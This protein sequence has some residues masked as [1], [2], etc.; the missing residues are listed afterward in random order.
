M[1]TSR[2]NLL[3]P[4]LICLVIVVTTSA[5]VLWVGFSDDTTRYM[6]LTGGAGWPPVH[7]AFPLGEYEQ[8]N[9]TQEDIR[10]YP[11][12]RDVFLPYATGERSFAIDVPITDNPFGHLKYIMLY[13][14]SER[15]AK[16]I[17]DKYGS[18]ARKIKRFMT[19]NGRNYS[20]TFFDTSVHV[21]D[22][23]L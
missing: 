5:A 12:F 10:H 18:H 17:L 1:K 16:E 8:V 19:Y 9:L 14:I 2:K 4:L 23:A 11:Y 20:V 3:I 13:R 6:T 7:E 22:A 21:A 15:E